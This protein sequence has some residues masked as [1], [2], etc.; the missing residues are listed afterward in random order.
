MCGIAGMWA[1]SFA[2]DVGLQETMLGS[3]RHRGPDSSGRWLSE[4]QTL[5]LLHTRL[6]IVDLTPQG[7][8]PMTSTCGDLV[9]TF[10]G[11]IYN[12]LD[13]RRQLDGKVVWRGHS[14]TETLLAAIQHWGVREALA[15][16]VGMF[17]FALWDKRHATLTLARDRLGEKPL[18]VAQ[19]EQGFYFASELKALRSCPGID[20]E[21]N[22]EAVSSYFQLGYVSTP[23]SIYRGIEKM[24]PGSFMVVKHWRQ[25]AARALY[26][27]VP[28]PVTHG[29]LRT[30]AEYIDA[31]EAC[32]RDAISA[33]LLADVPLGAFLSGGIDSSLITALMTQVASRQVKTFSMG[34][35]GSADD[36]SQ[37]AKVVASHLG[38]DH[39]ALMVSATDI[40]DMVPMVARTYDEPFADSSQ[41]PTMLLSKLTRQHVTVALTGDG[42]DEL[43]GGYNRHLMAHRLASSLGRIPLWG[44]KCLAAMLRLPAASRYDELAAWLKR[45]GIHRIPPQLSEK[46]LRMAAFIEASDERAC[47][48]STIIQSIAGGHLMPETDAGVTALRLPPCNG[49]LAAQMMWWDMQTYMPDDILVKVDRAAMA[50]SLETRAPFLDHRVV[51]LAQSLPLD[52]KINGRQS[53]WV[54]REVLARHVPHAM[55]ER[56]KQGFTLPIDQW[57]RG[58]LRDW[59]DAY[60]SGMSVR[61]SRHLDAKRVASMW[62][63]HQSGKRNHQRAL[64]TVLMFQTWLQENQ[65]LRSA[66]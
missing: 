7:H 2:T 46:I 37:H 35:A 30:P 4:D 50:F 56:P 63:E 14:D 55:F 17:A 13:I 57:L 41:V 24:A 47:Y 19:T 44:R 53:K 42:G 27:R 33:Q 34:I 21:L 39:T 22:E 5:T 58:P 38:T 61:Q 11:E 1:P 45:R 25:R 65:S 66:S 3:L 29:G 8:Q 23:H 51:E 16:L 18:Y 43:F 48:V 6:A 28:K 52:C 60:L 49:P 54:L 59:A 26:W 62:H 36:E 32:L 9:I 64:W 20:F 31:T 15:Q 10:N 40:I 12:H